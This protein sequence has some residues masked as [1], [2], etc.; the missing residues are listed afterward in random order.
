MYKRL[1]LYITALTFAVCVGSLILAL[2]ALFM[3]LS[4]DDFA[5]FYAFLPTVLQLWF[6][7]LLSLFTMVRW[8]CKVS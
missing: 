1:C 6:V 2:R 8:L 5:E 4:M 3:L 7:S